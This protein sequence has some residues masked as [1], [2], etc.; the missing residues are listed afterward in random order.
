MFGRSPSSCSGDSFIEE[1]EEENAVSHTPIAEPCSVSD[2]EAA[3]PCVD[4]P[5]ADAKW[6]SK[7]EDEVRENEELDQR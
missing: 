1:I 4:D 3:D 2:D 6:T 7:Y 5:F